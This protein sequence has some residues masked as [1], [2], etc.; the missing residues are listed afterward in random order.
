MVGG[1]VMRGRLFVATL[2]AVQGGCCAPSEPESPVQADPLEE[3]IAV[4]RF[5]D[6]VSM[7]LRLLARMPA[8]IP[9]DEALRQLGISEDD[10][11]GGWGNANTSVTSYH[12][13]PG[14]HLTL[15]IDLR[16]TYDGLPDRVIDA[17]VAVLSRQ[18]EDWWHS[19]FDSIFPYWQNGQMHYK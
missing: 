13:A 2:M 1:E 7:V 18:G 6:R 9:G 16:S 8:H 15:A 12:L 3:A 11:L 14:Y 10:A 19:D 4:G 5:P 17:R